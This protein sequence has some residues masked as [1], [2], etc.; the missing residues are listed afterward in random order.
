M[1]YILVT[2][3]LSKKRDT[4]RLEKFNHHGKYHG[5][6]VWLQ[7]DMERLSLSDKNVP[8]FMFINHQELKY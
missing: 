2:C 5:S 4:L 3:V 1:S 6:E 7:Y 8:K